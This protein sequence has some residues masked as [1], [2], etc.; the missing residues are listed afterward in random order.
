MPGKKGYDEERSNNQINI[1][2]ELAKTMIDKVVRRVLRAEEENNRQYKEI[3][4][5]KTLCIR[6]RRSGDNQHPTACQSSLANTRDILFS[7]FL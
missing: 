5:T 1:R 3:T 2:R 6:W 7:V 4:Y